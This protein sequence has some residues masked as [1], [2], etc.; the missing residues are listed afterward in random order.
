LKDLKNFEIYHNFV[1]PQVPK[2]IFGQGGPH[3]SIKLG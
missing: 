1:S 2:K 3:K